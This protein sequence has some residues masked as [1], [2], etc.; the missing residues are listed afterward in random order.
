MY[1]I[2]IGFSGFLKNPGTL[3]RTRHLDVLEFYRFLWFLKI[4]WYTLENETLGCTRGFMEF[5]GFL[6]P[7]G[8][9]GRMRLLGVPDFSGF[10]RK[11]GG[12]FVEGRTS[13]G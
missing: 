1:Q 7:S 10:S 4:I 12:F 3:W 13:K 2:F 11:S 6:K 9:L 8:T 5:S